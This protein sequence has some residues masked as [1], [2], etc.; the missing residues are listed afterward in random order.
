MSEMA[1]TQLKLGKGGHLCDQLGEGG[2]F[3][4]G[5]PALGVVRILL[6]SGSWL[7]VCTLAWL[8]GPRGLYNT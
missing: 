6:A 7:Q 3:R 5:V 4:L 2:S 8:P 1:R